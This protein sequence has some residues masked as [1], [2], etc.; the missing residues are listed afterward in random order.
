[1]AMENAD[2]HYLEAMAT[3]SRCEAKQ[4]GHHITRVFR[5]ARLHIFIDLYGARDT[6]SCHALFH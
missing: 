6:A 5:V 1:M 2:S 3:L 4:P